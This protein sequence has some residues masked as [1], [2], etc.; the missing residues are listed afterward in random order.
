MIRTAGFAAATLVAGAFTVLGAG[1]AHAAEGTVSIN[2]KLYENPTGCI[3]TGNS[4][5]TTV[6]NTTEKVVLVH[7]G[8]NCTGPV[9]GRVDPAGLALVPNGSLEIVE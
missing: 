1:A 4:F 2:G 8:R 6:G 5:Q 3:D 7:Q 9:I